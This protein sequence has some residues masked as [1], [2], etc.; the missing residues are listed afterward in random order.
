MRYLYNRVNVIYIYVLSFDIEYLKL[1]IIFSLLLFFFFFFFFNFYFF[2]FF[3]FF[4]LIVK[5]SGA[6]EK[7]NWKIQCLCFFIGSIFP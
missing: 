4:F 7:Q 1:Q 3:F 2:F 6:S 5:I